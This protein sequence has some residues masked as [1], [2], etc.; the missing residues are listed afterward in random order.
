MRGSAWTGTG[1]LLHKGGS[2]CLRGIFGGALPQHPPLPAPTAEQKGE[3]IFLPPPALQVMAVPTS[4][5]VEPTDKGETPQNLHGSTQMAWGKGGPTAHTQG[6]LGNAATVLTQQ[7][8][9]AKWGK[10]R[11]W[12]CE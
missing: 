4:E 3:E 7:I 5:P 6:H 2:L 11:G 1:R 12:S 9:S 10:C 8:R